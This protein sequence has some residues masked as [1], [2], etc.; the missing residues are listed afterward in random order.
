LLQVLFA[1]IFLDL[2]S[3]CAV[4]VLFLFPLALLLFSVSISISLVRVPHLRI[5]SLFSI[6]FCVRAIS[7]VF[8][9]SPTYKL[10]LFL[11]SFLSLSV[12]FSYTLPRP[13]LNHP[14]HC[15][16]AISHRL[17]MVLCCWNQA[18]Q[19]PMTRQWTLLPSFLT[20]LS[21][22]LLMMIRPPSSTIYI[23]V[24]TY[25]HLLHRF[26]YIYMYLSQCRARSRTTT[27]T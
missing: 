26:I 2:I 20:S 25:G 12:N 15:F 5:L 4:V 6:V 8:P 21:Q 10:V 17:R 7:F 9:S 14:M 27:S 19:G 1:R 24:Y 13:P 11:F 3:R 22:L 23:Y 16:T 18:T